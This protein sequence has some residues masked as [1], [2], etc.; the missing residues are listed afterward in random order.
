MHDRTPVAGLFPALLIWAGCNAA[1]SANY[2]S[3]ELVQ[4]S[5][6]VTLDEQPLPNAV[7]TFEAEDGQFSY[8]LTDS[9]GHYALQF[10]SEMSGVRPGK[11]TVR[12]STTR[13]ILGL[14]TDAEGGEEPSDEEGESV[15]AVSATER[16]PAKYNAESTL[17]ADVTAEQ[18]TFDFELQSN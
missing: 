2:D 12:I 16:I 10:D 5:G 11:K 18:T 6:Y 8:G 4:V 1:P 14:N 7:V 15:A 9:S 17:I 3:I 13:K